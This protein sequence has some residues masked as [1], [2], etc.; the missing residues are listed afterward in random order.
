MRVIREILPNL[1]KNQHNLPKLLLQLKEDLIFLNELTNIKNINLTIEEN[2]NIFKRKDILAKK[3]DMIHEVMKDNENLIAAQ[4]CVF[5]DSL[6][7][8]CKGVVS[9]GAGTNDFNLGFHSSGFNIFQYLPKGQGELSPIK[10]KQ[11]QKEQQSIE[12]KKEALAALERERKRRNITEEERQALMQEQRMMELKMWEDEEEKLFNEAYALYLDS[13]EYRKNTSELSVVVTAWEQLLN[14]KESRHPIALGTAVCQNNL[15]CV[16][17]HSYG[18][19]HPRSEASEY[20][21]EAA[22]KI[23]SNQLFDIERIIT[24]QLE[25]L[26]NGDKVDPRFAPIGDVVVNELNLGPIIVNNHVTIVTPCLLMLLNYM[27]ILYDNDNSLKLQE[28]FDYRRQLYELFHMLS[29]KEQNKFID[30]VVAE[31]NQMPV[32]AYQITTIKNIFYD[33]ISSDVILNLNIQEE[34]LKA[35]EIE[36]MRVSKENELVNKMENE[37]LDPLAQLSRD[38]RELRKERRN[39][40]LEQRRIDA[41]KRMEVSK[42]RK[43]LYDLIATDKISAIFNARAN[44]NAADNIPDW[45]VD[46]KAELSQLDETIT[47][48]ANTFI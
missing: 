43:T 46:N 21:M 14:L 13:Q 32:L 26:F 9:S 8:Y 31:V 47:K 10:E 44:D 23:A 4:S 30:G 16:L 45:G 41:M 34:R 22:A 39:K 11:L 33:K 48:M 25:I 42:Q 5:Y 24:S 28:T 2:S 15:G 17:V 20:L 35:K 3:I 40:Y 12:R 6:R 19:N 38:P 29:I 37:M 7:V 36:E 1:P 18:L 27:S